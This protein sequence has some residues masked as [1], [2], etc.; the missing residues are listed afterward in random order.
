MKNIEKNIA[1]PDKRKGDIKPK[2]KYPIHPFASMEVGDS[3]MVGT[4]SRDAMISICNAARAWA[5]QRSNEWKFS[6][7]KVGNNKM[8]V[9]RTQ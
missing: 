5:L 6:A 7:R 1:I 3:Y 8:R 4:Y 9:W 2:R